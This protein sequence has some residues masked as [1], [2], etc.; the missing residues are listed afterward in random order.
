V[1]KVDLVL[2]Y[3]LFFD[4]F[5][6]VVLVIAEVHGFVDDTKATAA[7][8]N[9]KLIVLV[10]VRQDHLFFEANKQVV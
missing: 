10:N 4:N 1:V 2:I 7:K 9:P 3:R 6:G 8:Y 5:Y